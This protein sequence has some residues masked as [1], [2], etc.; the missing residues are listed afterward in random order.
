MAVVKPDRAWH[1][2]HEQTRQ[3]TR[4]RLEATLALHR[5]TH[6]SAATSHVTRAAR[7]AIGAILSLSLMAAGSWPHGGKE[8]TTFIVREA[9]VHVEQAPRRREAVSESGSWRGAEVV[10]GEVEP[11]HGSGVVDVDLVIFIGICG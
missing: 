5:Q 6:G 2:A 11:G 10:A 7:A 8:R 3:Q 4:A 1:A 9:P